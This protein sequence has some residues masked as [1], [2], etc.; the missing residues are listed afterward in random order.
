[1]VVCVYIYIY[2][3]NKVII[4]NG[5]ARVHST[6]HCKSIIIILQLKKTN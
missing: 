2:L 4:K 1:M 6:Q 3:S 5:I